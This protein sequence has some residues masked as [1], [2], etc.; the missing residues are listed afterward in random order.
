MKLTKL[1]SLKLAVALTLA[2]LPLKALAQPERTLKTIALGHNSGTSISWNG[3]DEVITQM[4]LDNPSFAVMDIH[5]CVAGWNDCDTS[6][7][8]IIHLKRIEDLKLKNI[9]AASS[10]LLTVITE[11]RQTKETQLYFYEV[12]KASKTASNLVVAANAPTPE[13]VTVVR[14]NA[15]EPSQFDLPAEV[16]AAQI[17]AAIDQAQTHERLDRATKSSLVRFSSLLKLGTAESQAVA[18]SGVSTALV[19][20]IL[21]VNE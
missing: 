2:I 1:L 14:R 16:L 6:D 5:G 20:Q 18:Q 12:K 15:P 10:T 13:A 4:W 8:Q 19:K 21:A 11:N 17:D 7:A 3:S 9:P